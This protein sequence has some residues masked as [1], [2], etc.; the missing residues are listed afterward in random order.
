MKRNN[1]NRRLSELGQS[2]WLDFMRRSLITS[3]ELE[4]RT[5]ED[6]LRGVTS[7]PAI[8]EKAIDGSSDYDTDIRC[9]AEQGKTVDEIYSALT[10]KDIHDAADVMRPV[11][12][13]LDGRDGFV[14]LEVSPRLAH[15]T[16]GTIEAGRTDEY[17]AVGDTERLPRPRETEASPGGKPRRGTVDHGAASVVRHRPRRGHATTRKAGCGEVHGPLQSPHEFPGAEATGRTQRNRKNG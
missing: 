17:R 10:V 11:Y 9:L 12:D 4:R 1:P 6:R 8:F 5:V 14:S 7:N 16:D 15:D 2:L 3:G 13:A